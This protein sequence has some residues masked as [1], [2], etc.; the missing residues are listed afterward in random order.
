MGSKILKYFFEVNSEWFF[1]YAIIIFI[2]ILLDTFIVPGFFSAVGIN[3]KTLL[4]FLGISLV[5]KIYD[6]SK[7]HNY[8]RFVSHFLSH[9]KEFPIKIFLRKLTSLTWEKILSF[10]SILTIISWFFF[11][12]DRMREVVG[13][14]QNAGFQGYWPHLF[15]IA[16]YL[17]IISAIFRENDQNRQ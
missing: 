3:P 7:Q 10:G 4:I 14:F 5:L 2:M 16:L 6:H 13:I 17:S 1:N 15:S 8:Y 11:N 9:S 12:N